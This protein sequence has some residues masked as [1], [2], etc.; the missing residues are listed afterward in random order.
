MLLPSGVPF[1][2]LKAST[3]EVFRSAKF[4]LLAF[5]LETG[6]SRITQIE[7]GDSMDLWN[8]GILPQH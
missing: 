7:D 4:C 2:K 5:T 6:D 8:I 1:P 3:Y